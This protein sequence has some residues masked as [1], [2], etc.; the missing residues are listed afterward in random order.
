MFFDVY[1]PS[2]YAFVRRMSGSVTEAEDIT[3]DVFLRVHDGLRSY[4]PERDPRPWLFAI[5]A[6][7][8]RTSWRRAKA[9]VRGRTHAMGEGDDWHPDSADR[10]GVDAASRELDDRVRRAV[11]RLPEG[12][13]VPVLLRIYEGLPFDAI[14]QA[15]GLPAVTVR[16]RYS[17][18]LSKLRDLLGPVVGDVAAVVETE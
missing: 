10:P 8:V 16:K 13:R 3:Q 17:R 15:L 1:F 6:N 12:M 14:G 5:A 9:G 4:D 2:V 7:E 11:D 18:A